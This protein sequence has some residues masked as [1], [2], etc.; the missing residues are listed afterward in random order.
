MS[1]IEASRFPVV[2]R[3]GGA[4][5]HLEMVEAERTLDRLKVAIR[6]AGHCRVCGER[7][8]F[9]RTEGCTVAG[10]SVHDWVFIVGAYAVHPEGVR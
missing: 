7:D 1:S 6:D 3:F 4:V 2:F 9:Y 8:P 5:H 10:A